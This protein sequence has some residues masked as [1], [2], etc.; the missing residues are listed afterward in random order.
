M[1][2]EY[3]MGNGFGFMWI[4]PLIFLLLFFFFMKNIF[5]QNNHS[6]NSESKHESP[7]EILDKRLAR[8][9]IS[10]EEYEEIKKTMEGL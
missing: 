1:T 10:K 6:S 5:S 9:E 3:W 2:P 7:R 8:G 4:F